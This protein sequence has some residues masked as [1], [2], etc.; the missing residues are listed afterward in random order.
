MIEN[1]RK[2][3]INGIVD[4]ENRHG[5]LS[6]VDIFF[7]TD[8]PNER[9]KISHDLFLYEK[10]CMLE[11]P[12]KCDVLIM[13]V[14]MQKEPV[15]LSIISTRPKRVFLL[16]TDGSRTTAEKVMDDPDITSM[17]VEFKTVEIDEVDVAYNYRLLKDIVNEL[18]GNERVLVDPTGGRKTMGAI[19]GTFAFFFRIPMIYL[20]AEEIDNTVVPFTGVVCEIENPYTY[21]G[22]IE[23]SILKK[24]FDNYAFDAAIVICDE[25]LNTVKDMALH[26]KF[27]IIKEFIELY[28]DWDAFFHSRHYV[29]KAEREESANMARRLSDILNVKVNRFGLD[30]VDKSVVEGN[31]EFLD[32]IEQNWRPG[33]NLCDKFRLVDLLCNADR[34]AEQGKFDDAAARLY[35]CL[36]MCS[37]VKLEELGLKDVANPDY[38]VFA[39]A[40]GLSMDIIAKA[41]NT[42]GKWLPEMLALNQQMTLLGLVNEPIVSIYK[43]MQEGRDSLMNRRNRSVLAHGTNSII[44]RDYD[45]FRSRTMSIIIKTIGKGEFNV[46]SD[47]AMFPKLSSKL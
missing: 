39:D 40:N 6:L 21:Y 26:T 46:L 20:R 45:L 29:N 13:S 22:D 4:E 9:R 2:R 11:N 35:R 44:Q 42:D 5:A 43:G 38:Q 37:T 15:I 28:R 17:D 1:V 27:Q 32:R 36:E 25:L 33:M 23:L 10:K 18:D 30:F 34:R 12:M 16:H 8:N 24:H 7:G 19:L 31:I 14:G 47:K 41:F 3:I